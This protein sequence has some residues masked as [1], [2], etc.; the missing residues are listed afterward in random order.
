MKPLKKAAH[1][2]NE[3]GGQTP[4]IWELCK[5][6]TDCH[7]ECKKMVCAPNG[8]GKAHRRKPKVETNLRCLW[9]KETPA[10]KVWEKKSER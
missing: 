6:E 5:R 9:E 3:T 10:V 7:A 8:E 4:G 1:G 2:A